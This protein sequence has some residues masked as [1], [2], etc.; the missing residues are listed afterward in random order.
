MIC[1]TGCDIVETERFIKL[2]KNKAFVERYFNKKEIEFLPEKF[3][4]KD[5]CDEVKIQN[6]AQKL[7]SRYAAKEAFGKAL[8]T[9]IKGFSLT[10]VYVTNDSLGKPELNVT[11]LAQ[12]M[13]IERCG[14]NCKLH[15]SLSDEKNN[16]LA[17][18]IIENA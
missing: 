13:L 4:D 14:K 11:G 15:L 7:S 5:F 16:S 17:F 9:G 8:G 6:A 1:G 10:E 2:C 12:K 3:F 18:L